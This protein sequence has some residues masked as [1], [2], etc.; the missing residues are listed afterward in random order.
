MITDNRTL[1]KKDVSDL[2]SILQESFKKKFGNVNRTIDEIV[3][4][5][6]LIDLHFASNMVIMTYLHMNREKYEN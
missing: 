4:N 1:L 2:P 6:D 5:L 3:D